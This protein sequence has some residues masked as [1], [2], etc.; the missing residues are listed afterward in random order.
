MVLDGAKTKTGWWRSE[1]SEK[2][3]IVCGKS[4]DFPA[5]EFGK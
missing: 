1:Q 3:R 4:G 5:I 2:A